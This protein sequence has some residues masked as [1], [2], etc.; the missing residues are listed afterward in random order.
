MVSFNGNLDRDLYLRDQEKECKWHVEQERYAVQ[1]H[2]QRS[3]LQNSSGTANLHH[4]FGHNRS[5]ILD[6]FGHV[7]DAVLAKHNEHTRH[8][9][10][11]C[12]RI[13][14]HRRR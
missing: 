8:L 7:S 11:N 2:R 3:V 4:R 12:Q 9:E 1:D 14:I 13:N 10:P 6:L 5:R